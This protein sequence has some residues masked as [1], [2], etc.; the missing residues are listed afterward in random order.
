M[1]SH[2]R[3]I[4]WCSKAETRRAPS[5]QIDRAV[6]LMAQLSLSVPPDVKKISSGCAPMHAAMDS[7]AS[8]MA[9][10]GLREKSMA[11]TDCHT[12]PLTRATLPQMLCRIAVSWQRGRRRSFFITYR[13]N[14]ENSLQPSSLNSSIFS[15]SSSTVV[16]R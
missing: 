14:Q 8:A 3:R 16:S 11:E 7:R 4:A 2:A 6:P 5:L 10:R 1:A 9:F 12:L 13:L 15:F